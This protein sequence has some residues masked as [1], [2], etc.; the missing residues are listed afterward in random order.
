MFFLY[1]LAPNLSNG[2]LAET[3][4]FLTERYNAVRIGFILKNN[5]DRGYGADRPI[6]QTFQEVT[7]S[8]CEQFMLQP[9]IISK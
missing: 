5:N 4:N 6:Y 9:L 2:N 8:D 3:H 1:L 7:R